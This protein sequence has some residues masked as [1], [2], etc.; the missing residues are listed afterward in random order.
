MEAAEVLGISE[1]HFRRLRDA[2]EAGGAEDLSIVGALTHPVG[3]LGWTGLSSWASS[4]A[5][6][7]SVSRTNIYM[8]R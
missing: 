2:F 8:K 1:R 7:T 4:T 6:A 3:A 5:R